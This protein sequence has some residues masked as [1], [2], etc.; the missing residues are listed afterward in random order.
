KMHLYAPI[1]RVDLG[2]VLQNVKRPEGI[3]GDQMIFGIVRHRAV[4]LQPAS[5]GYSVARAALRS[6]MSGWRTSLQALGNPRSAQRQIVPTAREVG[7]QFRNAVEDYDKICIGEL[8]TAKPDAAAE[9]QPERRLRESPATAPCI[10]QTKG[11][12]GRG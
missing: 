10:G 12:L 9:I 3:V 5:H 1:V 2:A 8:G 7:R 11:R 6:R 4:R